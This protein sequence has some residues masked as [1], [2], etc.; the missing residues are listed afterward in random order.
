MME[1]EEKYCPENIRYVDDEWF[2]PSRHGHWGN[3]RQIGR[4]FQDLW[5]YPESEDTVCIAELEPTI[6]EQFH[7]LANEWSQEMS[8]VSSVTALVSHP[9]YQEI[10]RLG[11]KVVPFL[12][13][14]LKTNGDFWFPAL[15]EITGIRPFDR[16]DA[17]KS[18]RMTEAWIAWGKR[19]GII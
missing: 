17:G 8:T 13:V 18:K 12:L 16:R 14:D 6:E 1:T 9:K 4:M 11:W 15:A 19:K 2:A 5:Q 10:I 3:R 7:R